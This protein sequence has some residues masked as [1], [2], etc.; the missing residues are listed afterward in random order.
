MS[1]PSEGFPKLSA[2]HGPKASG[3]GSMS[4]QS[5]TLPFRV[6]DTESDTG[7]D[8]LG[9]RSLSAEH[10]NKCMLL[11]LVIC[12]VLA[13]IVLSAVGYLSEEQRLS[14]DDPSRAQ[15]GIEQ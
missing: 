7:T 6:I 4:I 11:L 3:L 5:N 1:G 2:I 14:V 9:G 8:A 12:I 10:I 15:L 13:G